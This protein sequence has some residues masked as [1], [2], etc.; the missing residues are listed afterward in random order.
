MM[1][2]F[3]RDN[4]VKVNLPAIQRSENIRE[5]SAK[6]VNKFTVQW[7]SLRVINCLL[8]SSSLVWNSL[9]RLSNW[10]TWKRFVRSY[11]SEFVLYGT[12]LQNT[13]LCCYQ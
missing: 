5:W 10:R 6:Q 7:V 4:P 12:H 13:L 1:N 9:L 11:K 8:D 3:S 2:V